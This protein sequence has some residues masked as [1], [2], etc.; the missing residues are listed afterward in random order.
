MPSSAKSGISRFLPPTPIFVRV[1]HRGRDLSKEAVYE[2]AELQR[3]EP[4][5]LLDKAA[6]SEQ[7]FYLK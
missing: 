1:D 5:R 4:D 3:G 7:L 2:E 6:V